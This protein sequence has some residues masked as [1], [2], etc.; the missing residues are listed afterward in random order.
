MQFANEDVAAPARWRTW[1]A[2]A[3][4]APAAGVLAAAL[5]GS[6]WKL[7]LAAV[8]V[9]ASLLVALRPSLRAHSTALSGH[10][11]DWGALLLCAG[12]AGAAGATAAAVLFVYIT[13]SALMFRTALEVLSLG[14]VFLTSWFLLRPDALPTLGPAFAVGL[15]LTLTG[16]RFRAGLVAHMSEVAAR[17]RQAE[18]QRLAADFHDGPL[19]TFSSLQIRLA[20]ARKLIDRDPKAAGQEIE[21]IQELGRTQCEELRAFLETL[22]KGPG[23][24]DFRASLLALVQNFERESGLKVSMNGLTATASPGAEVALEVLK[25]VREALHNVFKHAQASK[26]ELEFARSE[27]ALE[28]IVR[29]DGAGFP[30]AGSY[31]LEELEALQAGPESI[32]RRVR[33]FEG[34]LTLT[35]RPGSG[36]E[37]RI[38]LPL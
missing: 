20:L 27:G 19:Q 28:I 9:S 24:L 5:P 37:L 38:R 21:R 36:S 25:I 22:R 26:V 33:G 35:S 30:F 29:D 4:L 18:R 17:E 10:L 32:K 31:R 7:A 15:A 3:R 2:W 8:Y 23:E 13:T 11:A 12:L 1:H 14:A 6:R 34:E 16:C